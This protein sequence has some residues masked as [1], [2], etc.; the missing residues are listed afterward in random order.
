MSK[1]PNAGCCLVSTGQG[2]SKWSS[3]HLHR[4]EGAAPRTR[5]R[6][7]LSL[8]VMTGLAAGLNLKSFEY[9]FPPHPAQRTIHAF[10]APPT[11]TVSLPL[12]PT[13]QSRQKQTHLVAC[14]TFG[15]S[16]TAWS[17][18]TRIRKPTQ[19][20]KSMKMMR[21]KRF[22]AGGVG[23]LKRGSCASLRCSSLTSLVGS[24][25]GSLRFSGRVGSSEVARR[26]YLAGMVS[27][28]ERGGGSGRGMRWVY[29]S[30]AEG[31]VEEDSEREATNGGG[32]GRC[33]GGK[34]ENVLGAYDRCGSALISLRFPFGHSPC[35]G[36]LRLRRCSCTVGRRLQ[37]TSYCITLIGVG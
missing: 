11:C 23:G 20:R 29:T 28:C 16:S 19:R 2:L 32:G 21:A 15:D 27:G 3:T 10:T 31:F 25:D 33:A 6:P 12:P 13:H 1:R 7:S 26:S 14:T 35:Y 9:L 17:A 36:T 5:V 37:A 34:D 22:H 8:S 30:K 18:A 24:C 4:N